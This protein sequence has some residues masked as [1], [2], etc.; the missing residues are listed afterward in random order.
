MDISV[1]SESDAAPEADGRSQKNLQSCLACRGKAGPGISLH[2][3][4]KNAPAQKWAAACGVTIFPESARVC[5]VHFRP[6]D[7]KPSGRIVPTAVPTMNLNFAIP[8]PPLQMN[9][10]G[11]GQVGG[12][13]GGDVSDLEEG[14]VVVGDGNVSDMGEGDV[15]GGGGGDVAMEEDS[16]ASDD[17][18]FGCALQ[19][20]S[21]LDVACLGSAQDKER[22]TA[23]KLKLKFLQVRIR[24][25]PR[26][27][28]NFDN[29][30]LEF[31]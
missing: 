1:V 3:R 17:D 9:E 21:E 7:V 4:P 15:G 13:A 22:I 20:A 23:L 18:E 31:I 24:Q 2:R 19:L 8:L 30:L 6:E 28:T 11:T 16:D 29:S 5:R 12:E 10:P 14:D 27:E 26:S 25:I